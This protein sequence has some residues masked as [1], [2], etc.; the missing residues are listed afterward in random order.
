MTWRIDPFD[1]ATATEMELADVHALEVALER[2]ALPGEPTPPLAHSLAEYR[3]VPAFRSRNWWVARGGG[4]EVV[5]WAR[6]AWDDLP[7]NRSHCWGEILV[8][9]PARRQGIGSALLGLVAGSARE[10]GA[11]LLDVE[12]RSG[13]PG[14]PF[15]RSVGAELR[16]VERRS[17]LRPAEIDRARLMGWVER[18]R[19]RASGYSLLGWDG[20][21]PDEWLAAFCE[22]KAV[23]N[24][25]PL[26]D[27]ERDDDHLTPAQW[28]EW[29]AAMEAQDCDSWTL[30][31]LHEDSGEMAGLTEL[32]FPRRWPEMGY[33]EDTG[34]WPKHR[35]RGLG[36][37]LKAALALRLLDERPEVSRVETWN[38]GSNQAMLA[39]NTGLGFVPLE[40]WGAWQAPV[41]A[42]EA[43]LARPR[44]AG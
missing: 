32:V 40:E 35:E 18:A 37:W 12:T 28:R 41:D 10:W 34:V 19:E 27:L 44:G 38:A 5:G 15:L 9:A 3:R 16:Q 8:A 14:E 2:E 36:R 20:P 22:L 26:D 43:A 17:V 31:A 29:E 23:M 21:C 11:S 24:T 42:V 33:Q 6:C 25:A 7:E 13:G 30:C 39:I 1:P 4:G